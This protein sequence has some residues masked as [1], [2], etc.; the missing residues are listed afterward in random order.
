[1]EVSF[2]S[3]GIRLLTAILA[4][5]GFPRLGHR[6]G[7]NGLGTSQR[8]AAGALV[9]HRAA[10]RPVDGSANGRGLAVAGGALPA[11]GAVFLGLLGFLCCCLLSRRLLIRIVLL[12][13]LFIAC[14]A[15]FQRVVAKI[16]TVLAGSATYAFWIPKTCPVALCSANIHS[17]NCPNGILFI[18]SLIIYFSL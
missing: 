11:A 9:V 5:T 2:W 10:R 16:S 8:R 14:V 4:A 7:I 6:T 3:D 17:I 18:I 13:Q 12:F 1:M 15:G